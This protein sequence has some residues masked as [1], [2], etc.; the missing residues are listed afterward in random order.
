M[1]AWELIQQC[2]A[3]LQ[4]PTISVTSL[5]IH[6]N[7][8]L[9]FISYLNLKGLAPATITTYVAAIGYVHKCGN[10]SDPSRMFLVQKTLSCINKHHQQNDCRLPI[11][12]FVLARILESIPKLYS[13]PYHV[14]LLQALFS[15]AFYG[16]FRIGELTVQNT[17]V[18]SLL[19]K[20]VTVSSDRIVFSISKFK[21]NKSNQSFDVVINKQD[22]NVWCPVKLILKFVSLR[23]SQAGPF[24]CFANMQQVNR[25]FFTTRLSRCLQFCGFDTKLYKSHS[26]RIGGA[27]YLV[28]IG[29][30]DLQIKLMGRWESDCFIRYIRNQRYNV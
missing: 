9:A 21:N 2:M 13:V 3:C 10:F 19:S 28:S 26:F 11:T 12:Q 22:T 1:R 27:S 6:Q 29:Y 5:P 18:V 4:L 24:F 14:V 8:V 16:L 15:A 23:G 30:N 7:Q 17:G 20:N 25:N